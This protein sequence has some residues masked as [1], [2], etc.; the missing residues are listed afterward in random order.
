MPRV[1]NLPRNVAIVIVIASKHKPWNLFEMIITEDIFERGLKISAESSSKYFNDLH[2][3]EGS[4]FAK[5]FI[6]FTRK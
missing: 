6:S 4:D 5:R 2:A 3:N 1:S